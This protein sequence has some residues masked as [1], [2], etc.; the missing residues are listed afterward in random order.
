MVSIRLKGSIGGFEMV[1]MKSVYRFDHAVT[2][3]FSFSF[4]EVELSVVFWEDTAHVLL[5]NDKTTL[6]SVVKEE[7][8]LLQFLKTLTTLKI[9]QLQFVIRFKQSDLTREGRMVG[10]T[11]LDFDNATT[12]VVSQPATCTPTPYAL[13]FGSR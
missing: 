11:G 8:E 5:P 2:G 3:K 4:G 10:K 9:T 13:P 6:W 1:F 7:K 12:V